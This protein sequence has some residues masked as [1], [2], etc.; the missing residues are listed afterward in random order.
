MMNHRTTHRKDRRIIH[1]AHHLDMIRNPRRRCKSVPRHTPTP[2][3]PTAHRP[4]DHLHGLR[5]RLHRNT[6]KAE[7]NRRGARGNPGRHLIIG[8]GGQ[9]HRQRP[10]KRPL[11]TPSRPLGR[12]APESTPR[13]RPGFP[14][15][16]TQQCGAAKDC[17]A[18]GRPSS[19]RWASSAFLFSRQTHPIKRRHRGAPHRRRHPPNQ[20]TIGP[21]RE[22][23][24][25]HQRNAVIL[26]HIGSR[27][28]E[29]LAGEQHSRP[30]RPASVAVVL[31]CAQHVATGSQYSRHNPT[32]S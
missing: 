8:I 3:P 7:T 16:P 15:I 4:R 23:M 11:I 2:A 31:I 1:R 22:V 27:L 9:L 12:P 32:N 24:Q 13:R 29:T 26:R 18:C 25:R 6:A 5:R 10:H 14:A 20:L 21:D 28:L 30:P 17:V 19:R